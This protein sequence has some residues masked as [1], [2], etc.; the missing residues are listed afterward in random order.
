MKTSAEKGKLQIIKWKCRTKDDKPESFKMDVF[1][2]EKEM[3][4]ERGA[5]F[6]RENYHDVR[7]LREHA[8]GLRVCEIIAG[9]FHWSSR[10]WQ[11]DGMN[12]PLV[13]ERNGGKDKMM[14]GGREGR[15]KGENMSA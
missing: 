9:C 6:K 1:N 2:H 11:E 3:A 8:R 7:D 5:N 4:G 13:V 15:R 10:T 12:L 14:E